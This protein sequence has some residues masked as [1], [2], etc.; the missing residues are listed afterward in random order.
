MLLEHFTNG[1]STKSQVRESNI[2]W[3]TLKYTFHYYRLPLYTVHPTHNSKE[4][5]SAQV[6]TVHFQEQPKACPS[7]VQTCTHLCTDLPFLLRM[8][9]LEEKR[10]SHGLEGYAKRT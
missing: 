5:V 4:K 2:T 1:Y 6:C 10:W 7:S 8:L 3:Q 9:G